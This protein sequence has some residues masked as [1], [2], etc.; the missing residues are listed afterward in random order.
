MGKRKKQHRKRV[1]Q[2]NAQKANQQ[3]AVLNHLKELGITPAQAL[4]MIQNGEL[5]PNDEV[6]FGPKETELASPQHT[7]MLPESQRVASADG[8][9]DVR[10]GLV[11]P[12]SESGSDNDRPQDTQS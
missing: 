8:L 3:K 5:K 6:V 2:R 10:T 7:T 9:V 12:W 11:T 1:Q 4:Q